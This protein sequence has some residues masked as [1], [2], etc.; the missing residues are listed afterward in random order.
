[1]LSSSLT[2]NSG[3]TSP[4]VLHSP[5]G[6]LS[7]AEDLVL[8]VTDLFWVFIFIFQTA[9]AINTLE[10]SERNNRALGVPLNSGRFVLFMKSVVYEVLDGAG[11]FHSAWGYLF[12]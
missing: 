7:L 2:R 6:L 8:R 1:M 11:L 12:P 4:V 10:C 5:A 3:V 9:S